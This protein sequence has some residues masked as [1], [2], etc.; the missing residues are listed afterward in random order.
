MAKST[1]Y[2]PNDLSRRERTRKAGK[3]QWCEQKVALASQYEVYN[4]LEKGKVVVKKGA[5][6]TNNGNGHWCAECKDKRVKLSEA[7]LSR[8]N[9]ESK[10][11][12]KKAA[13]AK[14][15]KPAAKKSPAKRKP[16]KKAKASAADPF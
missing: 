15:K 9:G 8:R 12:P 11:K 3:C 2:P 1:Q 5:S 4:D 14:A 13:K 16:S 7:W 10:A 6:K